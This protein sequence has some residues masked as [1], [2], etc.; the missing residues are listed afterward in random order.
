MVNGIVVPVDGSPQCER[1]LPLVEALA[2][3]TGAAIHLLYLAETRVPQVDLESITPYRFEGLDWDGERWRREARE[4][5]ASYLVEL[6]GRLQLH[7][8]R[9]VTTTLLVTPTAG[10]VHRFADSAGADLLVVPVAG[11]EGESVWLGDVAARL[12]PRT[13]IPL[14]LVPPA[15]ADAAAENALKRVLIPLDGS[16]F[17]EQV[18]ARVRQ[19]DPARSMDLILLEIVQ[20]PRRGLPLSASGLPVGDADLMTRQGHAR[21]YLRRIAGELRKDGFS[22]TTR[23][24]VHRSAAGAILEAAREHEADCIAMATHGRGGLSRALLGSVAAEVLRAA[25]RPVLLYRPL[26]DMIL[27]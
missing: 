13:R 1:T 17:A 21:D 8:A 16:T 22:P 18:I 9:S 3:R 2:S 26:N 7:G 25:D 12:V 20:P 10:E 15:R 4:Q 19:L 11:A 23:V 5:E 24:M 6:A 27:F 14:L